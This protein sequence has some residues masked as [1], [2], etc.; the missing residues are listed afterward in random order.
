MLQRFQYERNQL[1]KLLYLT[2]FFSRTEFQRKPFENA[3]ELRQFL[4]TNKK[5]NEMVFKNK[6]D[7]EMK[8]P[9]QLFFY[10]LDN[11]DF[12][13]EISKFVNQVIYPV[14]ASYPVVYGNPLFYYDIITGKNPLLDIYQYLN[15][16]EINYEFF[17]G[18]AENVLQYVN[19]CN[20][21]TLCARSVLAFTKDLVEV[22]EAKQ[23]NAVITI[24]RLQKMCD[25]ILGKIQMK[26][27]IYYAE[28]LEH[29]ES[30]EK[31]RKIDMG[32]TS[33]EMFMLAKYSPSTFSIPERILTLLQ[34]NVALKNTDRL[35]IREM[36]IFNILYDMPFRIPNEQ[37]F[38][39]AFGKIISVSPLV[40]LNHN[41]N[42]RTLREL[43]KIIYENDAKEFKNIPEKT[44]YI[45]TSLI[46]FLSQV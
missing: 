9:S 39:K 42:I 25:R 35:V 2:N 37:E 41:A 11:N 23:E 6:C 26:Y 10:M 34:G 21:F 16:L 13:I 18:Q 38:S 24:S 17:L 32:S 27:E 7:L 45:L 30:Y 36:F 12:E 43:S 40:I 22:R 3:V 15:R 33:R 5:Y 8:D 31:M 20:L 29:P 14:K 1:A 4:I 19:V 44:R 46:G 28:S